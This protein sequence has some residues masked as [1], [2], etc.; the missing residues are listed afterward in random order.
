VLGNLLQNAAKFTPPGG[1]VVVSVSVENAEVEIRVRDTGVGVEAHQLE[2]MFEPF[3]QAEST[4]ARTKG[5]LGLGLAL[6][7][8]LVEMHGGRVFAKSEGLGHGC[9]I[10]V[11]L[12]R[13]MPP[14]VQE[15][16]A[17]VAT[18]S[19]SLVLLIEDNVDAAQTLADVLEL[20]GHRVHLAHD[21]ATGIH[22]ARTLKPDVVLCD[23][24]L[25]D[26]D[27]YEVARTLRAD[28]SLRSARLIAVTGYAHYADKQKA[29]E[30]GFDAHL[31]K[32][33]DLE[34][35]NALLAEEA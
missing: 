11:T 14:A 19:G 24:G 31:T 2:R 29:T 27:G 34:K 9:E 13:A 35:L 6:V 30:A 28:G 18:G 22:L 5:G 7:K 16:K 1:T 21:G 10:V 12:P 33:P 17:R 32:P 25:P 23:I 8:G 3:A 20:S 26:V 15:E 4:L